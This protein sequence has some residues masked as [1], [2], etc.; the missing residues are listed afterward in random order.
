MILSPRTDCNLH[1]KTGKELEESGELI[2]EVG[3]NN[4]AKWLNAEGRAGRDEVADS[5]CL[6]YES[7]GSEPKHNLG[8]AQNLLPTHYKH[9][10]VVKHNLK[11]M[12]DCDEVMAKLYKVVI[13]FSMA[14]QPYM[15]LG[16]LVSSRFHDHNQTH[17]TR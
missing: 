2:I 10:T 3:K 8:G 5:N 15:G 9:S 13:F 6:V 1:Q 17:H 14:R 4:T 7:G 16:L 11:G 12:T